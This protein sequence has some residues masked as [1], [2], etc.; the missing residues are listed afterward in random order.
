MLK[1]LQGQGFFF[2]F[3]FNARDGGAGQ[4]TVAGL[5][6]AIQSSSNEAGVLIKSRM[7]AGKQLEDPGCKSL[8]TVVDLLILN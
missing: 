4:A 1:H 6:A 5:H 3:L 8:L 2:F 7:K